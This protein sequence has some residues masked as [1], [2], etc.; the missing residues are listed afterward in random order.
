MNPTLSFQ[1]ITS[2]IEIEN[3][4]ERFDLDA[5]GAI[6]LGWPESVA[7]IPHCLLTG[8]YCS[9][10]VRMYVQEPY[11]WSRLRTVLCEPGGVVPLG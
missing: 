3:K 5:A 2:G 8:I 1:D 11:E 10:A 7:T 9:R 6:D 4:F